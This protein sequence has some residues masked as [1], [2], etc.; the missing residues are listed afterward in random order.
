MGCIRILAS[1]STRESAITVG[2]PRGAH[3]GTWEI[4]SRGAMAGGFPGVTA[5][6]TTFT[7]GTMATGRI[8]LTGCPGVRRWTG[9]GM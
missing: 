3:P 6:P 2:I 9:E 4:P 1:I 7:G 5:V 8:D